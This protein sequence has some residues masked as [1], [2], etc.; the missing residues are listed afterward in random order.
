MADPLSL[1]PDGEQGSR[2]VSRSNASLASSV[3]SDP[4]P[5]ANVTSDPKTTTKTSVS[6][7]KGKGKQSARAPS[8]KSRASSS[9]Q[10]RVLASMQ[11]K[12]EDFVTK[13]DFNELKDGLQELKTMFVSYVSNNSIDD[14]DEGGEENLEEEDLSLEDELDYFQSI[15]GTSESKGPKINTTIAKGVTKILQEGLTNEGKEKLTNSYNTPENC[16]RLNVVLC[17][18]PIYKN[19]KKPVR[20]VDKDLQTI[21]S[22][23][24]KGLT[25]NTYA[26][27]TLHKLC[28]DNKDTI[29][30]SEL[31]EEMKTIS[32]SISLVANAS[33]RLDVFR[34]QQFKSELNSDFVSLCSDSRPVGNSLF[35]QL[36]EDVKECSETARLTKR[37]HQTPNKAKRFRPY[38]YKKP[39][40]G[41]RGSHSRRGGGSRQYQY[42]QQR[43]YSQHKK[44]EPKKA[45]QRK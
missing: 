36:S 32:D 24:L 9:N 21:Q 22:D 43:Q 35:G 30:K 13:K 39:F 6:R 4:E 33:H 29:K 15:T 8:V 40:L 25:A 5:T 26:F 44:F 34:R 45:H 23:L 1:D 41:F 28:Q 31:Q 37:V 17:N 27:N 2:S 16:E 7:G 3:T 42:N 14:D 18:D 19:V 38:P 10:P 12:S 20:L 11:P